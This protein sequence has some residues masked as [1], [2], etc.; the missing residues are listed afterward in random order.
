MWTPQVGEAAQL[1]TPIRAELP[2]ALLACIRGRCRRG[3][4]C[5][6]HLLKSRRSAKP[7]LEELRLHRP[8]P[9]WFCCPCRAVVQSVPACHLLPARPTAPPALHSPGRQRAGHSSRISWSYS[10]MTLISGF[11]SLSFFTSQFKKST[12]S[13]RIPK[14]FPVHAHASHP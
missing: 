8:L 12:E 9:A 5:C 13:Q 4:R 10:I 2:A 7:P 3:C 14:N 1:G 6:I 11:R